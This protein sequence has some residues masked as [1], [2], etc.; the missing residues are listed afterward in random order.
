MDQGVFEKLMCN[1]NEL[2][3]ELTFRA[4]DKDEKPESL[5]SF[6][7]LLKQEERRVCWKE[8]TNPNL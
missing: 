4:D 8:Y 1:F 5:I 2:R 3:D 6:T 7:K